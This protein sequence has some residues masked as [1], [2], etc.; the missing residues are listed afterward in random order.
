MLFS[1]GT[2]Q[3]R[4]HPGFWGGARSGTPGFWEGMWIWCPRPNQCSL[5]CTGELLRGPHEAD[6]QWLGATPCDFCG[7]KSQCLYLPRFPPPAAGLLPRL[8]AATALRSAPAQGPKPCLGSDLQRAGC[9]E[10]PGPGPERLW[11]SPLWLFGPFGASLGA[12]GRIPQ[13]IWDQRYYS[14][15][16][17]AH[18]ESLPF[19][20]SLSLSSQLGGVIYGPLLFIN[21][22]LF[23]GM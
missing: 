18:P 19:E 13:G 17:P 15:G 20:I 3:V 8:A 10:D 2:V 4:A 12:P 9:D 11:A 5:V 1:D 22:H 21:R 14:W 23:I 16:W 6:P 7:P